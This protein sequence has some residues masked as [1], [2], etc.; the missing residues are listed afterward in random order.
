M[1]W[2]IA[3]AIV[4]CVNVVIGMISIDIHNKKENAWNLTL[5]NKMYGHKNFVCQ[6]VLAL[7][8]KNDAH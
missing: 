7:D 8:R 4:T 1:E 2:I 5:L 3:W 6:R